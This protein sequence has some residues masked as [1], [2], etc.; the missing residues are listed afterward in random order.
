MKIRCFGAVALIV[1][2]G[3]VAG[4]RAQAPSLMPSGLMY[5]YNTTQN[6]GWTNWNKVVDYTPP[7]GAPSWYDSSAVLVVPNQAN[8]TATKTFY[9]DLSYN[10]GVSANQAPTDISLQAG[11]PGNGLGAIGTLTAVNTSPN[12]SDLLY[13]WTLT[14]QPAQETLYFDSWAWSPGTGGGSPPANL[15]GI[16]VGSVCPEPTTLAVLG[17][18]AFGLL[19]CGRRWR[20]TRA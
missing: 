13:M 15:T 19:G 14:P 3:S 4:V 11:G 9:L 17:I 6:G 10:T 2:A 8:P 12:S 16:T 5:E 18:S 7:A 1:M 20:K